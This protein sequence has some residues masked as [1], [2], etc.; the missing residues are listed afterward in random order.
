MGNCK[1]CGSYKRFAGVGYKNRRTAR[2]ILDLATS[3]KRLTSRA[4]EIP[5]RLPLQSSDLC[6]YV[7][8]LVFDIPRLDAS[9]LRA[10]LQNA[11]TL[12]HCPHHSLRHDPL[13]AAASPLAPI[14]NLTI[15]VSQIPTKFGGK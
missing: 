6:R 4:N 13:E 15:H 12:A 8:S 11:R 1:G 10:P 3:V 2:A 9:V 14:R 5:Q 7:R